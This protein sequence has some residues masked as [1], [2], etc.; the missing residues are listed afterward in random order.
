MQ[1]NKYL[2]LCG[3]SSRRKAVLPIQEGRVR[4]NDRVVTEL[5]TEIDPQSDTIFLDGRQLVPP[6]SFRYILLNKPMG[7]ITSATDRRGRRTV[8]DCVDVEER[9]FPVG[10]L[11]YDTEGVLLLTNDGDLAYR[12]THPKYGVEKVYEARVE[13]CVRQSA[14]DSLKKGVS[15]G[16]NVVVKGEAEI[17]E[18]KEDETRIRIRV[19]EGKKRQIKRM[20][21]SVGHPVMHLTRVRFAGM[22]VGKLSGGEWRDLTDRE[23]ARLYKLT[24]LKKLSGGRE[25]QDTVLPSDQ[26][27]MIK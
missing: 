20:M 23:V 5:G 12:L 7:A 21:K 9:I 27:A 4:V 24:G 14:V 13:G 1:L 15:I 18:E 22:T 8:L 19:H 10:R 6:Q 26:E 25:H 2:A 11:D 16:E 3:F 17:L